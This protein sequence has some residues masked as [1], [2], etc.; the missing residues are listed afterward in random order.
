MA[1]ALIASFL[2]T[3]LWIT[4][5]LLLVHRKPCEHRLKAMTLAFLCSL[6][7]LLLFLFLLQQQT[8]IVLKLNGHEN[9]SLAY[10]YALL[11]HL[12]FFLFFVECF[13][14]L[15]RS[16]TLRILIEIGQTLTPV[17]VEAME[18]DYSLDDM[19]TRRLNDMLNSGWLYQKNG[20]W[21]LSQKALF[22]AKTMRFSCWLFQSKPQD[23]RL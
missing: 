14:H 22:L 13:Y 4:M 23:Q 2:V 15:E 6:P 12:L 7:V 5:H 20:C 16:V 8:A 21:M 3:L 11:L 9:Y 1:T 18:K 17:K 19:I 10:S